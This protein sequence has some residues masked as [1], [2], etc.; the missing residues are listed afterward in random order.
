MAESP[1]QKNN[2][3][4]KQEQ[5]KPLRTFEGDVAEALQEGKTSTVRIV[6]AQ[7]ARAREPEAESKTV[8]ENP[9]PANPERRKFLLIASGAIVF[10]GIIGFVA[11]LILKP[12]DKP[13]TPFTSNGQAFMTIDVDK[14]I[15]LTGLDQKQSVD[16][17]KRERDAAVLR[18]NSTESITLTQKDASGTLRQITAGEFVSKISPNTPQSFVRSLENNFMFGLIGFDGNQPF[19]ILRTNS[20]ENA[21]GGLLASEFDFYREAGNIFIPPGTSLPGISPETLSYFGTDPN[22]QIFQDTVVKNVDAR[23][24]KNSKGDD[25]FL[26]AFPDQATII[27]T[28]NQKTF[29]EIIDRLKRSQLI[30]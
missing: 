13:P 15:D 11:Y 10:A 14:T 17:I 27:I 9:E 25:I 18:V 8:L 7:Q 22:N 3:S 30:R 2:G 23:V 6:S 5:I 12:E 4:A 21:Y 19:L 26:Y 28:T 29:G 24:V 20:F 1:D 16:A